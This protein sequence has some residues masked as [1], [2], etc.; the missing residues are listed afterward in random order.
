MAGAD[1]AAAGPGG[2]RLSLISWGQ[3]RN[4]FQD[5]ELARLLMQW[6]LFRFLVRDL[7]FRICAIRRAAILWDGHAVGSA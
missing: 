2:K 5:K 7:H 3:Y 4:Y 1:A 6:L